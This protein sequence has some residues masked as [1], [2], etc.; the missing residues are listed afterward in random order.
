MIR[1]TVIYE[2]F[3]T[4]SGDVDVI[5]EIN[6]KGPAGA[7]AQVD[8]AVVGHNK[9]GPKSLERVGEPHV[10][11]ETIPGNAETAQAFEQAITRDRSV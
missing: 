5:H 3:H 6:V 11:G 1:N 8:R 9:T 10:H 7:V 4:K 2:R